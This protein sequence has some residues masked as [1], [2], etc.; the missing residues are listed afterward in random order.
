MRARMH[1]HTH[2]RVHACILEE[3]GIFRV[4]LLRVYQG[5]KR[6]QRFDVH[7]WYHVRIERNKAIARIER[8]FVN[9]A[10][11][12]ASDGRYN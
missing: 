9:S 7:W 8:R 11:P 10:I 3:K 12:F 2:M 4:E 1:A 5:R 6:I